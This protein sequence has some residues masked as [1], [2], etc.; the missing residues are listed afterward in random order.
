MWTS[1]G[2]TVRWPV[3]LT[4]C[5]VKF[6][7]VSWQVSMSLS[8]SWLS[9]SLVN[10]KV[11]PSGTKTC[12]RLTPACHNKQSKGRKRS[13]SWPPVW[14]AWLFESDNP[15]H[16]HSH[17]MRDLPCR[18]KRSRLPC[19]RLTQSQTHTTHT[20]QY[21]WFWR[22]HSTTDPPRSKQRLASQSVP[23]VY[24]NLY[25][26]PHSWRSLG[27]NPHD[28]AVSGLRTLFEYASLVVFIC[29]VITEV[30]RMSLPFK[31]FIALADI[32]MATPLE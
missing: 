24:A 21:L 10:Q 31:S 4:H 32:T 19:R 13:W 28:V 26:F 7:C 30:I 5:F 27:S 25:H 1:V 17:C 3:L 29:F 20:F 15:V 9:Y 6:E 8:C 11:L 22:I 12:S 16:L 18:S 2:L 23:H 14:Y